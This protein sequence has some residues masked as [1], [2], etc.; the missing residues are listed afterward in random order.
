MY[1][2]IKVDE[3]SIVFR[4]NGGAAE[5]CEQIRFSHVHNTMMRVFVTD[6][7]SFH[8]SDGAKKTK[9]KKEIIYLHYRMTI[10]YYY[11]YIYDNKTTHKISQY[12]T[13]CTNLKRHNISRTLDTRTTGPI[14]SEREYCKETSVR[15][16]CVN[17]RY[18]GLNRIPS[19]QSPRDRREKS[20]TAWAQVAHEIRIEKRTRK[21]RRTTDLHKFMF[22]LCVR[23]SR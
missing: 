10:L 2:N 7:F 8:F 3:I 19:S 20:E 1:F 23:N 11:R 9:K 13:R 5:P 15:R 17:I 16:I 6:H 22:I 4:K 21:P 14:S 12:F 18:N